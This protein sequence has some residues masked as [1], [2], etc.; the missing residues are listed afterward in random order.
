MYR[1][2]FF[3]IDG[4]LISKQDLSIPASLKEAIKQLKANGIYVGIATGRHT[5]EIEEVN[6]LQDLEFDFYVTL[7]GQI[8]FENKQLVYSQAIDKNDIDT[9]LKVSSTHQIPLLFIEENDMYMNMIN[10]DVIK[11]QASIHTM[12]PPI[13]KVNP[14]QNFYQVCAYLK[15]EQLYLFDNL[16]HTTIT[17]WHDAAYDLI[18]DQGSKTEGI[19]AV[20][21]PHGISLDEV[22]CFGDGDNDADM[23]AH[24]GLGIAMGVASDKARSAAKESCDTVE[25]DGIYKALKKHQMI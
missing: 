15:P 16:K 23:L 22:I 25:N 2:V 20:L 7:N 13:K 19:A 24:C 6:L 18:S 10:D 1:A 9:L 3:D 21:K 4:T 12:L 17:Q 14:N 8:C 11:A 5:I